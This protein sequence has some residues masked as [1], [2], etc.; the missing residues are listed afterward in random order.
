[1]IN[2]RSLQY[3]LNQAQKL[4]EKSYSKQIKIGIISSYTVNGLAE[5]LQ[6]KCA[7]NNVNCRHY[8]GA[9]NQ[10]SQEIISKDSELYKFA[11]DIVFLLLDTRS[12]FGNVFYDSYSLNLEERKLFV[13]EKFEEIE[14]L[15]NIFSKNLNLKL[16]ISNFTIP[17]YSPFGIN[18]TKQDYGFH[19]MILSLN[20][21]LN[22]SFREKYDVYIFDFNSFS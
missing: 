16:I 21:K 17:S 22:L 10:Y 5:T 19:E 3:Y 15:V 8:V 2:E 13:K 1:M 14:N 9:Y 7:E 11:P 20:S 18:E 4:E 6:V 12:F